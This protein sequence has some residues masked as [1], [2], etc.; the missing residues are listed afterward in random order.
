M[1]TDPRPT[2]AIQVVT[3]TP[4][5]AEAHRIGAALVEQ[6]LAACVQVVGPITSIYRW[7]GRLEVSQEWLCI[8]KTRTALYSSVEERI[9]ALHSYTLPEILAFTVEHGER[10]YLDWLRQETT[11]P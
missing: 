11:E 7:Q 4:T 9:R 3:A 8:I 10:G 6:R 1:E 5:E 2:D